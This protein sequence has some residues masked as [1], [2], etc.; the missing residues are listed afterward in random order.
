[1]FKASTLVLVWASVFG[2]M[3]TEPAEEYGRWWTKSKK[4]GEAERRLEP[5]VGHYD[6]TM[7]LWSAPSADSVVVKGTSVHEMILGG[8]ILQVRDEYPELNLS[9]IGLHF[10]DAVKSKYVNLAGSSK[11]GWL[12]GWEGQ[13]DDENKTLTYRETTVDA[14]SGERVNRKGV[15]RLDEKGYVYENFQ[16]PPGGDE[17]RTRRSIYRRKN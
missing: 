10:Y 2:W 8:W 14:V 4:P 3:G 13:F 12:G 6:V 5:F 16:A 9:F 17:W 15:A 11:T 1:M 7:I